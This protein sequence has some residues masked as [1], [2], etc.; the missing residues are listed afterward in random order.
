MKFASCLDF[1]FYKIYT[2]QRIYMMVLRSAELQGEMA[3]AIYVIDVTLLSVTL[4][5]LAMASKAGKES[6]SEAC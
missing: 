6:D 2:E 3:S 4:L 1:Q 5:S